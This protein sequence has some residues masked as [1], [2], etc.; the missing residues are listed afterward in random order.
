MGNEQTFS[1]SR[2]G[3]RVTVATVRCDRCGAM[4]EPSG[5]LLPLGWM[6]TLRPERQPLVLCT[7][8]VWVVHHQTALV[9]CREH[10][11]LRP[12]EVLAPTYRALQA[13]GPVTAAQLGE[14]LGIEGETAR[15][16]VRRLI[17]RKYAR[18]VPGTY[19]AL[20]EA[21]QA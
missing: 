21:V 10:R 4:A 11:P 7:D 15:A 14:A 5:G 2:V 18:Q 19:P 8:C 20:Y 12:T 3:A 6:R 9:A 16:R 17:T 13:I 1:S